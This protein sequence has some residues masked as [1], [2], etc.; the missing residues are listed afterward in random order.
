MELHVVTNY[1]RAL[2]LLRTMIRRAYWGKNQLEEYQRRRLREVVTYAY[3]KSKFH[4]DRFRDAGI[5]PEDIKTVEDLNRVPILRKKEFGDNVE[6][7]VSVDHG[8]K[9]L[10][11]MRTSGSTGKPL[12]VYVTQEEDEFR[13]EKHLRANMAYGQK[14]RDRWVTITSPLHFAETNGF[15]RFL[16]IYS[17]SPVSVF[18]D[19]STQFMKI[20]K[21]KPD[22]ID[23]YS[24]SLLLLAKEAKREGEKSIM[25]GLR[26]RHLVGGAELIDPGSRRF[27][28]EVFEAPF[29][30]QYA[31]VELERMAWQCEEKQ[32]YHIDADSII[33]QFVDEDGVEVAGG[34]R[35]EV[36]VT[37]LFNF[38]MPIIRYALDD[39]GVPSENTSCTCGR[40]FPQM[41]ALEGRRTSLLTFPGERVLAPFA[42]MLA[43][44]TFKY[45]DSIDLFRIEQK[46]KDLLLFT[47]TLKT[48]RIGGKLIADEL[49]KHFS[50]VL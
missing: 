48:T 19:L 25:S 17:P 15:Q 8:L 42:F 41:K 22:I 31:C 37:S 3:E 38:A 28:E 46:R 45:Y 16:G 33:M 18:D 30:D 26:P 39:F 49:I 14:L 24:N 4:H 23:G 7:V 6:K 40:S 36:V 12:H 50:I 43:M 47:L 27:V 32:D 9:D 13:K 10:K 20:Q 2:C 1:F 29:Y 21:L 44:W 5:K 35:G 11:V 34:E